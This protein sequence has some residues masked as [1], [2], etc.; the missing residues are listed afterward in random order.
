MPVAGRSRPASRPRSGCTRLHKQSPPCGEIDGQLVPRA[1]F[2]G[3]TV[4]DTIT[5][6]PH[7]GDAPLQSTRCTD[8]PRMMP[9]VIQSRTPEALR[10]HVGCA[11]RGARPSYVH[12]L[13]TGHEVRLPSFLL[14]P[15][16]EI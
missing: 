9:F 15:V 16:A 1:P 7:D 5:Q 14:Q 3:K 13:R 4:T 12:D 6:Q 2:A 8:E 10:Q 11:L